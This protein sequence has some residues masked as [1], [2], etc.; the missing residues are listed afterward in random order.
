M[1][2]QDP[3]RTK[4]QMMLLE[5]APFRPKFAN[6]GL[7]LYTAKYGVH[8]SAIFYAGI[9]ACTLIAGCI[10]AVHIGDPMVFARSGSL[11]IAYGVFFGVLGVDGTIKKDL[12]YFQY[13]YEAM[14]QDELE[15]LQKKDALTN[16]DFTDLVVTAVQKAFTERSFSDLSGKIIRRTWYVDAVVLFIGTLVWGFGDLAIYGSPDACSVCS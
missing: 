12:K 3:P 1:T 2:A 16:K 9:A 5:L 10:T 14:Q 13:I 6:V 15:R 11:L 4:A 8:I 7:K